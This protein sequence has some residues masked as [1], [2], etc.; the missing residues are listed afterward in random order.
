MRRRLLVL[1]VALGAVVAGP[2]LADW[3]RAESRNFIVYSDGSERVLRDYVRRLEVY[4]FILRARTGRSDE[5]TYY[6]LPIF[7]LSSRRQLEVIYDGDRA[8]AGVYFATSEGPFAVAL[9]G[10]G[11]EDSDDIIFHEYFHH[12]SH[13]TGGLSAAPGW[14]IEGMA[15][16]YMTAEITAQSVEIGGF[17]E[18]RAY[19]LVNA[20]WIPVEDLLRKSPADYTR[21]EQVSAYYSQAWLLMHWFL[22]DAE[23]R[24]QLT[25]ALQD[26]AEGADPVA[27]VEQRTGLG[28]EALQRELR[29][30]MR[31]RLNAIRYEFPRR[32][33]EMTVTR[34]PPSADDLLLL[35]QRLKL[36]GDE[37]ERAA[38]AETVRRAAARHPEDSFAR[39]Q[40]G[41]AELHFGDAVAGEAI[42]TRLLEAEPQNVEALQLMATRRLQ[43]AEETPDQARV[44]SREAL[45]FL[46]RAYA[47]EPTHYYT[48]ML[49]AR[50]REWADDYPNDNDI[51]AWTQ[52]Y[53][54][55]PQLAESRL[56]LSR[57]L[58]MRERFEEAADL[59]RPL[60]NAPHGGGAAGYARELLRSAEAREGPG[61]QV[62][63]EALA[64][65]EPVAPQ[66]EEGEPA[67]RPEPGPPPA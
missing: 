35:S 32:E 11:V 60:A 52:A 46:A 27:A 26:M 48:L 53:L 15:E 25:G 20:R 13:Q 64:P 2:A 67:P 57:A 62:D 28:P 55:A 1:L 22:S 54:L 59:L 4:D 7:L 12:F 63:M 38:L 66:S 24:A 23:R 37:R 33:V 9:R 29:A 31:D 30:Y 50:S 6:K 56:G 17:N 16:Y 5:E 18:S 34:L 65:P 21:P 61:V 39:L 47:V 19:W 49:I 51:E 40:L 8:L 44:R 3:R 36:P 45:A 14:V 43:Q 58:M 10:D 41:H 42:L